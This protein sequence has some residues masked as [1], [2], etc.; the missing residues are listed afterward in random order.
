MFASKIGSLN[1][2]F[3]GSSV[4]RKLCQT[5]FEETK[6]PF[7]ID[8]MDYDEKPGYDNPWRK[9]SN[10]EYPSELH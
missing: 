6:M 4:V 5:M 3:K 9:K 7:K 8:K 1:A 2:E 10:N